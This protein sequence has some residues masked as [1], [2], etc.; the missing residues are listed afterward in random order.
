M[1]PGNHYRWDKGEVNGTLANVLRGRS[2]SK[3][4]IPCEENAWNGWND[5][6]FTA[7]LD[8][9]EELSIHKTSTGI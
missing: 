1:E 3:G 2:P 5:P 6:L 9:V 4:S 7:A 8:V